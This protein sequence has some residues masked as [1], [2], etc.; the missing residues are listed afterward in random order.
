[1]AVKCLKGI[2]KALEMCVKVERM[3]KEVKYRLW[4]NYLNYT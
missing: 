1:M 4:G 3:R 2:N